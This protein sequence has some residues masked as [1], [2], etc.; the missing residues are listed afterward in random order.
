MLERLRQNAQSWGIKIA[1]G[2]IIVVFVFYFGMGNFSDKKEPVVAYVGKDAISAREFQK[3][4]EDA[5]TSMRRQNPGASAEELNT[6]QFKQAILAELVN[7]RLLL[8]AARDMGVTVSAPE[9]RAVISSIPAFHGA[10]G[11]FDPA[12]YKNSLAQNRTTPKVF[13]DELKTS[14]IIQKLQGFSAVAAW[15]SEPEAKGLF[16]WARETV[17]VDTLAFPLAAL[18]G[19]VNPGEE[20]LKAQYEASKDRYKEPA[21]IR[22]EYL[23]IS[24]ADL[25]AAQKVS[26]EDV[27]KQYEANAD[28][29]KHPAQLRARH[30]LLQ[31]PENAPQNVADTVLAT[32]KGIQEQLKKGASFEALAKKFSQDP[33]SASKGG[34]LPWFAEGA[35]VKPFEDAAK[36][37]KPGQVSEPVRTQFGWHLIKLEAARPAGKVALEEAAPELRKRMAEERASEK[38]NEILDQSM[39]EIAAGVKLG[40]IAQKLGLATQKSDMLDMASV[41]SQFGLKKEAAETLFALADGEGA[42]TPLSMEPAR[43]YLLAER[44]E[45]KPEAV[46]PFESVKD[47]VLAEVRREETRKLALEKAKAVLAQLSGADAAA[48]MAQHKAEIRTSSPLDRQGAIALAGGNPQFVQDIFSGAAGVWLKQPYELPDAV[49]LAR[50]GERIPAPEGEWDKEK[51]LWMSQGA[52]AFRQELFEALLKNLRATVKVEIVRQDLLN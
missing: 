18:A 22:L 38:I 31:V 19:E 4:Y 28:A 27:R 15:V 11:A 9:L 49:V 47:K 6:P 52:A 51:R 25:A 34:E 39:D 2:I 7:T 5:V 43:G 21:R 42:K 3:A 33:G 26:D 23:P 40:K 8:A 46:L 17:R 1:F 41:Q 24:I 48:A 32:V 14:Q 35:M 30:I 37:L 20:Q 45:G 10:N 12:I 29:F 44:I 13:E 36:A 16:Q 50:V